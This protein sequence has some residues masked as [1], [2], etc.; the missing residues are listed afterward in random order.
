[1]I[2]QVTKKTKPMT[3]QRAGIEANIMASAF[4]TRKNSLGRSTSKDTGFKGICRYP[5]KATESK[6][7]PVCWNDLEDYI[8]SFT[9][10][11]RDGSDILFVN[12]FKLDQGW[13]SV[14]WV[15]KSYGVYWRE[16][17]EAVPAELSQSPVLQACKAI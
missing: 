9:G 4:K 1:M 2:I 13:H 15:V 12:W 3:E 11:L 8:R 7:T 14:W 17:R 6:W 10:G 5:K 16:E